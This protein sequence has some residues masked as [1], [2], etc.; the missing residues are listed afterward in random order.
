MVIDSSACLD[1]LL[2]TDRGDAF[3]E[4]LL[5]PEPPLLAP[6]L[7]WIETAAV[8]RAKV[9]AGEIRARLADES[10]A[11]LLDLGVVE[12]ETE[13]LVTRAWQLRDNFTVSDGV[14][15]ALA[16]AAGQPLMTAD[17]RLAAAAQAHTGIAVLTHEGELD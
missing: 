15:V 14:F 9:I 4:L 16:E 6:A 17:V 12:V 10:L 3:R 11:S 7:L 1:V 5:D 13:S 2:G 8:L